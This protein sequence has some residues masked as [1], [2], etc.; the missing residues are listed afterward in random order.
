M[1]YNSIFDVIGH[2]IVGPSSSHT[3][4]ACQIAYI[5]Q[6]LFGKTPQFVKIGLHGSFAETYRGH[7]SDVAIVGGLCGLTPDDERI[8]KSFQIAQEKGMQF[9]FE[10]M[11][12][13]SDYHPNTILLE[14]H[15]NTDV[16]TI[17]GSS[18]GG[19]NVVINEIDGMEAGFMGDF[20]TII[21][22]NQDKVGII[23]KISDAISKSKLNIGS[24]KVF[25]DPH[26]KQSLIWIELDST[27]PPDLITQ[28]KMIPEIKWVR[29]LNV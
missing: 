1:K 18:I 8:S 2:I 14:M 24:M 16:L 21:I 25:R 6:L 27:I 5:A 26:K 11:D 13:G 22:L 15:D 3:A 23:A 10:S 19:G 28:L 9:V 7:G 4:G 29:T 17:I 20:P 12:L